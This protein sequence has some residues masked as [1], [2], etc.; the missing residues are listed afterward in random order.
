[1]IGSEDQTKTKPT[2]FREENDNSAFLLGLLMNKERDNTTN[3]GKLK[4]RFVT[5]NMEITSISTSKCL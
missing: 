4:I 5:Q 3:S 2:Y 1:M